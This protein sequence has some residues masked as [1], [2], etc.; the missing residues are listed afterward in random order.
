LTW[1]A[2]TVEQ[3]GNPSTA[4]YPGVTPSGTTVFGGPVAGAVFT[5]VFFYTANSSV[6]NITRQN[7]NSL[8]TAGTQMPL[9]SGASPT[10]VPAGTAATVAGLVIPYQPGVRINWAFGAYYPEGGVITS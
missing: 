2:P 8:M 1:A 9:R 4:S 6:T 5:L 10:S 7:I 3:I